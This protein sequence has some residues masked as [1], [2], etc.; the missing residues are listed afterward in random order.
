MKG[1]DPS[2]SRRLC[3]LP[4]AVM[5]L[6]PDGAPRDIGK[7]YRASFLGSACCILLYTVYG[8]IFVRHHAL[9][10]S[11]EMDLLLRS[12][13]TPLITPLDPHLQAFGHQVGSALF[14]GFTLGV[15]N[16]L[17]CMVMTLPAWNRGRVERKDLLLL[18]VPAVTCTFL[19]FSRELP[20]VSII[21]GVLCPL[22]FA[23]PWTGVLR[24]GPAIE[25]NILRWAICTGILCAPFILLVFM[26]PSFLMVRDSMLGMPVAR[27]LSGFYYS[28]TLL[29]ADVIKPPAARPQSV[30][31]VSRDIDRI[32]PLPHGILWVQTPVPCS[33]KAATFVVSRQPAGC[34][35]IILRDR[36]PAN[37]GG[38]IF[39]A[40]GKVFDR[41]AQMRLAI[42]IFLFSGPLI[43]VLFLLISW[44]GLG[45]ERLSRH[46]IA[47]SSAVI[48]AYLVLFVP[49][50]HTAFLGIQ[51]RAHPERIRAYLD[52]GVENKQYLVASTFPGSLSLRDI[53]S[54]MR[55]KS[56]RIRINTIIE[57][58]QRRD[59]ALTNAMERSLK[60]PQLNVRTKACWSL[61]RI[62]S[63]RALLLLDKVVR[64][65]QS[66]YV[67]EYAY[68][69][70]GTIRPEA[71]VIQADF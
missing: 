24:R 33:V 49:A 28:H 40:Y 59:P 64:E 55:S 18:L 10:I 5:S 29:A 35:S 31:A 7:W 57:A 51:L 58:G 19:G 65:D 42:G 14:F 2:T 61:G 25:R 46:S 44:L 22:V 67:R 38:R 6:Q 32:G 66:W 9:K 11:G 71:K 8:L 16:A 3:P 36:L 62:G 13:M 70:L 12:G 54:M 27:A 39:K 26:R 17:V 47:S 60:D 37:A 21:C 4:V 68:S 1:T 52:S 45:L 43:I 34:T 50:W 20:A 63:D 15:L 69:A 48:A 23:L 53:E 30:I 56:A 41:N